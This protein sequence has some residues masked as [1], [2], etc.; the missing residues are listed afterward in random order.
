[1]GDLGVVFG[2]EV[3]LERA[4]V[5]DWAVYRDGELVLGGFS[6]GSAGGTTTGG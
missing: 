6:I 5:E 3:S 1:V 2:D 4:D